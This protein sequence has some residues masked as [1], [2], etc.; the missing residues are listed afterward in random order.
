MG[1]QQKVY[2]PMKSLDPVL[3]ARSAQV[4]LLLEA[5]Q[6]PKRADTQM[7]DIDE[8]SRQAINSQ[9]VPSIIGE[10]IL[11]LSSMPHGVEKAIAYSAIIAKA[12]LARTKRG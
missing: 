11:L 4:P 3:N 12:R 2:V 9:F 5:S 8:L 10:H 6:T 1:D 7:P